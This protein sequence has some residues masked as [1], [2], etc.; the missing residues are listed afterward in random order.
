MNFIFGII[1]YL[2]IILSVMHNWFLLVFVIVVVFSL[3][4]RSALLIPLAI[5]L[6]GYYGAFYTL[7]VLSTMSIVWFVFIEYLKPKLL[8]NRD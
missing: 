4:F 8:A 2:A 7:P 5:F 3:K 6:D 1:L